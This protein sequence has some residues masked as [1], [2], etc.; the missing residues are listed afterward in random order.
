M[1]SLVNDVDNLCRYPTR[2]TGT[3]GHAAAKRYL[4]RRF[5]DLGLRPYVGTSFELPYGTSHHDLVNL[6]GI[7]PHPGPSHAPVLI[8]AHYD[9]VTSTPGADD[10]AAAI[11]IAL[12]VTRRLVENPAARPVVLASFDA[13][14]PP[15]FRTVAMGSTRFVGEQMRE[16]VHAALILDLVGHRIE[17]AGF[18]D[19]AAVMGS[20]SH[21]QL[22]A[23]VSESN[24]KHLP[25][26]TLPNRIYPDMSD[27]YAFRIAGIPYLFFTCGQGEHYHRPTDTPDTLDYRKM[28]RVADLLEELVRT[29]AAAPMSR[30]EEHDTSEL[31]VANLRKLLGDG[32]SDMLGLRTAGDFDDVIRRVILALQGG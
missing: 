10:N 25:V 4:L 27:H 5:A 9:T 32:A 30:A 8:G 26:A 22:A 12:E 7:T 23:A 17:Q 14:E 13:E 15:H 18:S 3:E 11:A 31:D 24:G 1:S 19:M 28:E 20:E 29:S 21:P 2:A 16:R 6:I